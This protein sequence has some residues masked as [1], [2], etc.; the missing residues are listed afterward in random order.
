MATLD[1]NQ[2]MSNKKTVTFYIARSSAI[3]QYATLEQ[4]LCQLFSSLLGTPQNLGAIVF[5][6]ITAA[7]YRLEIIEKLIKKT[8]KTEYL[9]FWGGV[10]SEC[11]KLDNTRNNIIHWNISTDLNVT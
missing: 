9:E 2:A 8:G 7:R 4:S 6:K 5:F 10:Q 1:L 3:Q 11:N